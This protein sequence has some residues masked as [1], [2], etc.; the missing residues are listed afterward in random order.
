M[1]Y[2]VDLSGVTSRAELHRRIADCLPI[3]DWYGKNLDSLCDALSDPI[4]G[5]DCRVTFR[6][7][8]E[9]RDKLPD[10]YKAMGSMC[11]AAMAQNQGLQIEFC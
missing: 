5:G 8:G 1:D 11:D 6:N 10:Y 2:T 3:P 9:F 7:C 4:F